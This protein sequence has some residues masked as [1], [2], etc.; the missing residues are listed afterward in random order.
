MLNLTNQKI[1]HLKSKLFSDGIVIKHDVYSNL[2][3]VSFKINNGEK[4]LKFRYPDAFRDG[5]LEAANEKLQ[6]RILE[7][8]NEFPELE[9]KSENKLT[10]KG[11]LAER[12][13]SNLMHFTKLD[14]LTSIINHGLLSI[15]KLKEK[16]INYHFND[17]KRHDERED[18]ICTSVEFPNSANLRKFRHDYP[19]CSWA[20]VVLDAQLILNHTCFFAEHNA[21]TSYI[22][23]SLKSRQSAEAFEGIFANIV[24]GKANTAGK[25]DTYSRKQMRNNVSCLPTSYQAEILVKDHID[26]R[27]IK[28]VIFMNDDDMK[29]Y[30]DILAAKKIGTRVFY[31]LFTLNRDDFPTEVLQW[32]QK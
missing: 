19:D 2:F 13:I 6:Q 5:F 17:S 15:D 26:V 22:K 24:Q 11:I 27:H 18:C 16:N 10:I 1:I 9:N 21:A 3:W 29:Q 23:N 7:E 31:N 8:K 4:T 20:I 12:K 25:N 28:D 30:R 14:N 32:L